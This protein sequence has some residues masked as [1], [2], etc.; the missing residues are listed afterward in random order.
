MQEGFYFPGQTVPEGSETAWLDHGTETPVDVVY[1]VSWPDDT[2]TMKVGEILIEAKYG[3]PQ[4]NGQCSVD[5]IYQTVQ[6]QNASLSS[7]QLVDPVQTRSVSLE[8]VPQDISTSYSGAETVFPDL[9][10]T[11]FYRISYDP[12]D[13]LL[14]CKGVLVDPVLGFDYVLLNVLTQEDYQALLDLSPNDE[15]WRT[16]TAALYAL[17]AQ[18]IRIN[19]STTDPFE[20]LALTSGFAQGTGYVT[21]A[22]QNAESCAPLPVS[23]EILRVVPELEPGR[24]AVVKPGCVFEETLTLR[25]T[26]DFGGNPGNFEFQW[27]YLPDEDGTLP[28][29][30]D[31]SAPNDPWD[32]P[33]MNEPTT[34][35]GLNE[36]TISG[37]GLLTLTDNWFVVRYRDN[38]PG[39]DWSGVWSD[40][41]DPMLE[42]GWIKRVVGQINPFTQRA[43][44][45]GI[46]GAEASFASFQDD[47]INT[48]VSMISQAGPRWTGSVPLNCDNLDDFGLIPIYETVLNRGADLSINALS[49]VDH[50]GVN[51]ALLLA[52]SRI[53]DLYD[54]LGNEAYADAADPT[55]AFGT[56]DEVYGAEASSIHCFMNQTSSLLEEELNLLRGRGEPDFG[57]GMQ[58]YP[59]YN[60]MI[61]NFT[62][63]M[64]GGEVAYALNYNIRDDV[65]SGD[66]EISEADAKRLYPQGH[67]DAWGHYLK[68]IKTYYSLLRHPYYTWVPRSEAV[69]VGGGPVTVDYLDE[70]KFARTAA[71]KARTG[72]EIVNLAYREDYVEDPAGQWQGYPDTAI[73]ERAWGFSDWAS[74]AAQGAFLDWVVG[75]AII[76]AEDPDPDH[77]SI[78]KVDRTTVTDL[79]EVVAAFQEITAQVDM[80][81]LG[82]NPLGLGTNVI[83]FDISP[84]LIDDGFTHFEQVYE[85]SLTALNNALTTFNNAAN[86]TQLLRRQADSLEDLE[87]SVEAQE[88]D[89]NSQLIEIFG[90][91]YSDDIG[92]GG[93]YDSDYDGPDIYHYAYVD[94]SDLMGQDQP[95]DLTW[96][97]TV[98]DSMTSS[99]AAL[100]LPAN[101]LTYTEN[102]VDMNF[103]IRGSSFGLIKP[104]TWTG[105]RRAPANCSSR[106]RK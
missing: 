7:V 77:T 3:L 50:P 28:S 5:L 18:P 105:S 30:P 58:E 16:A 9:P 80:A 60:R 42:E 96:Q 1:T 59:I 84:S 65:Y 52:A 40:W 23:L 55:I 53:N 93:A 91:P 13:G 66:G 83:P 95:R 92:P 57:P 94:V 31:L 24:I 73:P 85:R 97:I 87:R 62:R 104:S 79:D 86:S 32:D 47:Q 100:T 36:I 70:R 99:T 12:V 41:T 4:I 20:V 71:A 26:N 82:L 67:G 8:S 15:A 37:P 101:A 98:R 17:C 11:L 103:S 90:Y 19:D 29:P 75:N 22:M 76:P 2:P 48:L 78:A 25:H 54:L 46:E 64:T 89:F 61:W 38:T 74:R 81:D 44:G 102:T 39:L 43:G 69:L 106:A 45:G 72:A 49:P 21:L 63:D 56:D 14:K 51:T 27:L 68:A 34:G 6:A 33:P 10:P 35:M 88:S